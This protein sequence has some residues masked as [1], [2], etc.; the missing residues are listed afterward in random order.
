MALDTGI[1]PWLQRNW[2]PRE[3]FDPTPWLQERYNRQIEAQ[4]LPLQ[5]QGMALQNEAE[6][7]AIQH[8]GMVNEAAGLELQLYK[9]DIPVLDAESKEIAKNPMGIVG[10][11][12]PPLKST[13]ARNQWL[14]WQQA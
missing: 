14:D 10:R 7:L 8:Q 5:L 1:P 4:K 9:Q 2:A 12:M 11:Q 6:N 3:P 13:R